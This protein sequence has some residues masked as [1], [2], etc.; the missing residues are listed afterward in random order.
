MTNY[1]TIHGVKKRSFVIQAKMPELLSTVIARV[2]SSDTRVT[3]NGDIRVT[4][5]GDVR[6][7]HNTTNI[8]PRIIDGVRKRTFRIHAKVK[9]G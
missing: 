1:I 8:Y 5:N 3:R 4:R 9:H 7:A 2:N 6:I